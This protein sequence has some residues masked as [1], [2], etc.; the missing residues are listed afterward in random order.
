MGSPVASI[1]CMTKRLLENK[2]HRL[3]GISVLRGSNYLVAKPVIPVE[4][5][6]AACCIVWRATCNR[7]NKRHGALIGVVGWI[8]AVRARDL[9]SFKSHFV[10]WSALRSRGVPRVSQSTFAVLAVC[11]DIVECWLC[12]AWPLPPKSN[13]IFLAVKRQTCLHII[14]NAWR[15]SIPTFVR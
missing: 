11:L 8:A 9:F 7:T 10:Y 6:F 5:A 14:F 12:A 3:A 2:F 4:S 1:K 13:A 15:A